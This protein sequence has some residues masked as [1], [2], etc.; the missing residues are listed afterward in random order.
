MT[1][2]TYVKM[3]GPAIKSDALSQL[4]ELMYRNG[5][6]A[7]ELAKRTGYKLK[8]VRRLLKETAQLTV[9]DLVIFTLATGG[10]CSINIVPEQEP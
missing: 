10:V 6:S 1:V 2:D 9:K 8:Y 4:R 5:V 7:E 3:F